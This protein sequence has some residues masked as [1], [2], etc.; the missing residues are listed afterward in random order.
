M[1]LSELGPVRRCPHVFEEVEDTAGL[2]DPLDLSE[3]V[4][5]AADGA[6]DKGDDDGVERICFE[7]AQVLAVSLHQLADGVP[8][9][10]VF[11]VVK[12]VRFKAKVG[13]GHRPVH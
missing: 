11:A 10:P 4:L 1:E 5:D 7:L 2:Q 12:E 8:I 3:G 9:L 13:L 6:Q